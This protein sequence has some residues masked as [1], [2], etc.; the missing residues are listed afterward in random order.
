[1]K[2]P[3]PRLKASEEAP[4]SFKDAASLITVGEPEEAVRIARRICRRG[5]QGPG[6][7][8]NLAA[9]LIDAGVAVGRSRWIREGRKL[10]EGLR[11]DASRA[12][13]LAS[14]EYNVGNAWAALSRTERRGST[15]SRQAQHEA[16][17]ALARSVEIDGSRADPA[18]NL[19]SLLL[20]QGRVIEAIDLFTDII[21]TASHHPMARLKRA[22]ALEFLFRTVRS[23][24]ALL[25]AALA[26]AEAALSL[27]DPYPEYRRACEEVVTSLAPRV[28]EKREHG[29]PT[30]ARPETAWIWDAR[31]A[32]NP[33][34]RCRTHA[35]ASFDTFVLDGFL[36]APR[37]RPPVAIL[38]E[39]VNSWHR[40]FSSARWSLMQAVGIL[41]ELPTNH[42]VNLQGVDGAHADLATGIL[43]SAVAGFHALF[44][45]VAWGLNAYLHL[46]HS[47]RD[48]TLFNIWRPA[49]S[50]PLAGHR[51]PV[52]RG[53]FHHAFRSQ[54]GPTAALYG[55]ARSLKDSDGL[56][57]AL[58]DLRN[59][60]THHVVVVSDPPLRSPYVAP[61]SRRALEQD[62]ISLGRL[63]KAA[64]WYGGAT[65]QWYEFQRARK[66]ARK[67]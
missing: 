41:G 38:V 4:P 31:L 16:I 9:I 13:R 30:D 59:A 8:H 6:Y 54:P 18:I 36:E 49:G 66:A 24:K 3:A 25:E 17:S 44:D 26:D 52:L 27:T 20:E 67:G 15:A 45:Q 53:E 19:G 56:Y 48:A 47:R 60:A 50:K 29:I 22:V 62:A 65:I 11:D 1:M 23:T 51:L 40:T 32:L 57:R 35:P 39:I 46:G 34:P 63:A 58:R 7:R 28:A 55:L 2:A 14:F 61:L 64:L 37:R 10:L 5:R 33:C 43:L 42:V 12:G 21:E